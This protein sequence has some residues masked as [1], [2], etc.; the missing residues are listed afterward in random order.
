MSDRADRIRHRLLRMHAESD[1]GHVGGNLSAIDVMTV[2]H[3]DVMTADDVFILSKGHAA[4]ALYTVLWSKG[5]LT[6][7]ELQSWCADGTTLPGHP[8]ASIPGVLFSTGSLGHGL[9]LALGVAMGKS[10]QRDA[11]H[12]YC[13]MSDGEWQEGSCWEALMLAAHRHPENLTVVVDN[14]GLQGLGTT[15]ETLSM[16]DLSPRLAA[17]GARVVNVDGH[18]EDRIR[19]VLEEAKSAGFTVVCADTVKGR[20][21]SYEGT[22]ASHYLPLTSEDRDNLN[23]IRKEA[24]E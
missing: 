12:T 21:M 6:D 5:L 2:L 14:N 20:G 22:V 4:G 18:D 10:W 17:F 23:A 13:L 24:A 7:E 3:H 19:Q 9:S 1:A 8:V 16:G 11:G 15:Q